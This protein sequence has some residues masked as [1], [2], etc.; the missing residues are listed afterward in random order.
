MR[1]M[2]QRIRARHMLTCCHN[3]CGKFEAGPL[4]FHTPPSKKRDLLV[5][6]TSMNERWI[7][8]KFTFDRNWE[9]ERILV[10]KIPEFTWNP[11]PVTTL[12][13]HVQIMPTRAMT[14]TKYWVGQNFYSHRSGWSTRME[15][16]IYGPQTTKPNL[17]CLV[18]LHSY[19]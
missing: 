15:P 18:G 2:W 3:A 5:G 14:P 4:Q 10:Q 8:G 12:V 1:T 6:S 7:R 13:D 17:M 11:A 9:I 16:R 19:Q